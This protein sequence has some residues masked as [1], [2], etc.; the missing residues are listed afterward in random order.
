MATQRKPRPEITP[1]AVLDI[2]RRVSNGEKQASIAYSYGI[3]QPAVC[4]IARG[5]RRM[6]VMSDTPETICTKPQG[7]YKARS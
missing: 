3:T 7:G 4:Q 5:K 2:R 1:E 6:D